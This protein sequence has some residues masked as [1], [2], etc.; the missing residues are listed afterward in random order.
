MGTDSAGWL[1]RNS[2]QANLP[3]DPGEHAATTGEVDHAL[4]WGF[5]SRHLKAEIPNAFVADYAGQHPGRVI[6]IAAVDPADPDAVDRLEGIAERSEFGG[7]TVCPAGQAFHPADTR[8]MRIYECCAERGLPVFFESGVDLAATAVTEYARP[9]LLDEV[10]RTFAGLTVVVGDM[11]RPWVDETLVLLA[12][13]PNVHADVAALI[14]RPWQAYRALMSAH[15]HGVGGKLLFGS[16]FP[17]S[18]TSAAIE[19]LYRLNE[20]AH[21]TNLPTVPREVLRGI[22]ERDVLSA[23]GLRRP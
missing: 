6:G 10:A 8:A 9:V 5:R 20:V 22:V 2:G 15:E 7:V 12:K 23:L 1:E 3:A 14:R 21:G 13:H 16:D 19:Q 11:G 18:T 4:V 17:F